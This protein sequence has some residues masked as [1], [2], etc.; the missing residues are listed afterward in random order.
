MQISLKAA[1]VNAELT[2][3]QAAKALGANTS[4]VVNWEMGRTSPTALQLQNL[5]A[6][7]GMDSIDSIFLLKK[8]S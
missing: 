2:Q 7:Y 6:I 1:R 8:S 5:C 3:K 4:T